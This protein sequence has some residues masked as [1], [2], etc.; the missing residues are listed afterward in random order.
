MA[1]QRQ[2][3][4]KG[5]STQADSIENGAA[6][7]EKADGTKA[8]KKAEPASKSAPDDAQGSQKIASLS[9]ALEG[10]LST[11]DPDTALESI[12][13]FQSLLKQS[14]QPEAKEIASGLKELQKLLKRPE[15][16]GHELGELISHL[17]EQTIEIAADTDKAL[18]T[19]LQHLGKQL[20]KIGR[21]LAKAEDSEQ[22]ED[23]DSLVDTLKQSPDK[24][25]AKASVGEIDRW[26]DLLHKSED[27]SLKEIATDL[28]ALKQILKGSKTKGGELS[29][30]LI[31]LGE[32]T[33]ASAA[34]AGRG[35]KGAI[36]KLGKALTTFGKSLA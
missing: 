10:D 34:D 5:E 15:P 30:K 32:K 7:Q 2:I 20:T 9:Q 23:L 16:S 8:S 19:P 27:S 17:G 24:I 18:K 12:E 4:D 21:S 3:Q 14:K 13:A 36:Q 29:E 35:F 1:S 11:L 33:T 22:L 26:Y 28:K 6:Q 31:E 25:D